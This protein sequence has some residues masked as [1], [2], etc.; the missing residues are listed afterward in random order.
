MRHSNSN[1]SYKGSPEK[2]ARWSI[3]TMAAKDQSSNNES[4]GNSESPD[5]QIINEGEVTSPKKTIKSF[6]KACNS[7]TTNSSPGRI[8][9][10]RRKNG[11]PELHSSPKRTL[12]YNDV[13][14]VDTELDVIEIPIA[15][16]SFQTRQPPILMDDI[17]ASQANPKNGANSSSNSTAKPST[18]DADFPDDFDPDIV[19]LSIVL[20]CENSPEKSSENSTINNSTNANGCGAQRTTETNVAVKQGRNVD[21]SSC[22]NASSTSPWKVINIQ[23]PDRLMTALSSDWQSTLDVTKKQPSNDIITTGITDDNLMQR[24]SIRSTTNTPIKSSPRRALFSPPNTQRNLCSE[25]EHC[26]PNLPTKTNGS[27]N[28]PTKIYGVSNSPMKMNGSSKLSTKSN[29]ASSSSKEPYPSS[30]TTPIKTP[31]RNA[32]PPFSPRVKTT[33]HKARSDR[34]D[35]DLATRA[36]ENLNQAKQGVIPLNDF[37]L[38]AIYAKK[39]FELEYGSL[40]TSTAIKYEAKDL[41]DPEDKHADH[42]FMVL[43]NVFSEP[44]NCGYFNDYELDTIFSL[45]TLSPKAQSL[46]VRMLKRKRGWHRVTAIQYPEIDPDLKPFFRELVEHG[47]LD[48]GKDLKE[49]LPR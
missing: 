22:G 16:P 45:L 12:T 29:R 42:F 30:N 13:V 3:P 49:C 6:A 27:T 43:V 31:T 19:E 9:L 44:M 7:P 17:S 15:A 33:P 1:E 23:T 32:K 25:A 10:K 14:P 47:F 40:D 37:D 46:L 48:D 35:T 11:V 20:S 24:N 4:G 36:V 39:S 2:L 28:S 8:S 34:V 41:R 26:A 38:E 5:I 21:L 18:P